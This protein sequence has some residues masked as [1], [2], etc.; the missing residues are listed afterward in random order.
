VNLN[1]ARVFVLDIKEAKTSIPAR[2]TV[3]LELMCGFGAPA[4]CHAYAPLG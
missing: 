3:S 4:H 2:L 1:T